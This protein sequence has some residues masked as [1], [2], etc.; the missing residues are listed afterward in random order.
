MLL[1]WILLV[2]MSIYRNDES[3]WSTSALTSEFGGV[4]LARSSI[5]SFSSIDP[6]SSFKKIYL[7]YSLKISVNQQAITFLKKLKIGEFGIGSETMDV[8]MLTDSGSVSVFRL[9]R[10]TGDNDSTVATFATT[11]S[12]PSLSQVN[13]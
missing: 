6:E 12:K 1:G 2:L 9:A 10:A 4:E 7:K 5:S 8:A 11:T 3:K 13:I